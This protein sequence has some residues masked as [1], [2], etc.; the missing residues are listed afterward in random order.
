M[1]NGE[2]RKHE[3]QLFEKAEECHA[4]FP[5]PS[6]F[7]PFPLTLSFSVIPLKQNQKVGNKRSL[8]AG[9]QLLCA[10]SYFWLG[11][12]YHMTRSSQ[13]AKQSKP[14]PRAPN[15]SH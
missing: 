3:D 7:K 9:E 11:M 6:G 13:N 10:G 1:A 2:A 4:A 8:Q 15:L 14:E 5:H 12:K